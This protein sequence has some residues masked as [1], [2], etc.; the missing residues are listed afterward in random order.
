MLLC[1]KECITDA[2]PC[3]P[4]KIRSFNKHIPFQFASL[5]TFLIIIYFN[6]IRRAKSERQRKFKRTPEIYR[7]LKPFS[8]RLYHPVVGWGHIHQ[9]LYGSVGKKLKKKTNFFFSSNIICHSSRKVLVLAQFK[10]DSYSKRDKEKRINSL[11]SFCNGNFIL[12]PSIY[13]SQVFM[14]DNKYFSSIF[15]LALLFDVL[16]VFILAKWKGNEKTVEPA[17]LLRTVQQLIFL[18][19]ARRDSN[20]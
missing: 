14:L 17:S 6:I 8:A 20:E 13:F 11:I 3:H 12:F 10:F 16:W 18:R 1:Y 4:F 2:F 19:N 15:A 7:I 5:L 9:M